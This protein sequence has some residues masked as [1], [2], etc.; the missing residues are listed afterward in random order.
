M[1]IAALKAGIGAECPFR[2][3]PEYM[4]ALDR[5]PLGIN[6]AVTGEWNY[7]G[8][9]RRT[10]YSGMGG[11]PFQ[12][13]RNQFDAVGDDRATDRIPLEVLTGRDAFVD[14]FRE[15]AQELRA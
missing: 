15:L 5:R 14:V 9:D 11:F 10:F 3:F 8:G 6:V 4:D 1:S 2:T 12:T 13:E 7:Q